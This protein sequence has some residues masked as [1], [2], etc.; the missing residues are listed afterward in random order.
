MEI[1]ARATRKIPLE[2]I[3][4]ALPRTAGPRHILRSRSC[5]RS[6]VLQFICSQ[7]YYSALPKSPKFIGVNTETVRFAQMNRRIDPSLGC[8]PFIESVLS[9]TPT[10]FCDTHVSLSQGVFHVLRFGENVAVVLDSVE[11]RFP[12]RQNRDDAIEF[13]R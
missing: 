4:A 7:R 3:R 8:A 11:L 2:P 1:T 10:S 13:G 12:L 5:E 9:Q 6:V